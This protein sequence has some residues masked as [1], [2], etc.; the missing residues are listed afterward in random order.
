MFDKGS[1]NG[2]QLK[3]AHR[4]FASGRNALEKDWRDKKAYNS[5]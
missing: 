4:R 3:F 1:G 2:L 5:D